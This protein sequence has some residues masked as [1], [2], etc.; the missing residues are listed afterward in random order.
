MFN[1][2]NSAHRR[3]TDGVLL[4]RTRLTATYNCS[5][6]FLTFTMR[7]NSHSGAD[8]GSTLR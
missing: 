5:A 4:R 3:L 8:I 7:R 1:S 6:A 2:T